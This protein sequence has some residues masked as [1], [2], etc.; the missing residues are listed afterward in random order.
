MEEKAYREQTRRS[1]REEFL[2][3]I[4]VKVVNQVGNLGKPLAF[5]D[6][7]RA[8]QGFFLRFPHGF[9]MCTAS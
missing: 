1:K 9:G 7:E 3:T 8:E 5:H 4:V 6:Y 2:F